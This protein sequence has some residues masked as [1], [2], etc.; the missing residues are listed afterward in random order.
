MARN[1]SRPPAARPASTLRP[2]VRV[3]LLV[4][5]LPDG[6]AVLD[7]SGNVVHLLNPAAAYIMSLCDGNRTERALTLALRQAVPTLEP[8]VAEHD[9]HTALEQ[10]SSAGV[11][12]GRNAPESR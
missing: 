10:L 4:R 7:M 6:C 12:R 2:A 9:V 5:D 3:D 8:E 1:S 11:L